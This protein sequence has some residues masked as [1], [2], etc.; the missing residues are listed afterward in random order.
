M[1]FITAPLIGLASIPVA[2]ILSA[3]VLNPIVAARVRSMFA[4]QTIHRRDL[5]LIVVGTL[6]LCAYAIVG[7][8]L[9]GFAACAVLVASSLYSFASAMKWSGLGA[10]AE[11]RL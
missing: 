7:S 11:D 4:I 6:M 3:L 1:P 9:V 5:A 2:M 8:P 10:D